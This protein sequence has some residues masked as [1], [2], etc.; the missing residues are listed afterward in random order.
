MPLFDSS[1]QNPNQFFNYF[2]NKNSIRY[3]FQF[4]LVES[5]KVEKS[6]SR[7]VRKS[8]SRKVE[9]SESRKVGKSKSRKVEK[10][11]V[12]HSITHHRLLASSQSRINFNQSI[13]QPINCHPEPAC[14]A[15]RRSRRAI[16]HFQTLFHCVTQCLHG[17]TLWPF[18]FYILHSISLSCVSRDKLFYILHFT[19]CFRLSDF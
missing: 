3:H 10:S 4:Q 14:S 2:F 19:S 17:V 8:K 18:T 7:K 11:K 5:Q 15:D 1:I 12:S 9:K 13:N 6:E 16:K